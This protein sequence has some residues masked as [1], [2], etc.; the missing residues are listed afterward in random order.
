MLPFRADWMSSKLLQL[1]GKDESHSSEP[2]SS[3][4]AGGSKNSAR[5]ASRD[6]YLHLASSK[7]SDTQSHA[8][9]AACCPGEGDEHRRYHQCA[10]MRVLSCDLEEALK[11]PVPDGDSAAI[12]SLRQLKRSAELR[13]QAREVTGLQLG[14]VLVLQH[15]SHTASTHILAMKRHAQP[16]KP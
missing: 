9:N 11:K 4:H 12:E 10:L 14:F 13:L 15:S 6:K 16:H 8:H 1:V 5:S 3:A 7:S 2:S